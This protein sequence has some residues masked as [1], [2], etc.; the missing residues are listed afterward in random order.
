MPTGE[1]V[2][3]FTQLCTPCRAGFLPTPAPGRAAQQAS[4]VAREPL[5]PQHLCLQHRKQPDAPEEKPR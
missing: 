5:Q 2:P 4:Q 3:A 1:T